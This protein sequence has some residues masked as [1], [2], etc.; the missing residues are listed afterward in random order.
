MHPAIQGRKAHPKFKPPKVAQ[1]FLQ[2]ERLKEKEKVKARAD[3][4]MKV[5]GKGG[6]CFKRKNETLLDIFFHH[7]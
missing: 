5:E 6:K 1:C 2:A 3:A 7:C 4:W